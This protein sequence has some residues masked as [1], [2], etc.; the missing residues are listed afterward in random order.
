VRQK[1]VNHCFFRSR[2]RIQE[3]HSVWFDFGSFVPDLKVA[4]T[5][6]AST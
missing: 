5:A 1:F 2:C 3:P 4:D 6:A